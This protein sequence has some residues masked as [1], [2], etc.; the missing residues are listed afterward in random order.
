[1]GLGD[2]QD[3]RAEQISQLPA[4][5]NVSLDSMSPKNVRG[6]RRIKLIVQTPLN[7]G[8]AC[9]S[10]EHHSPFGF[11]SKGAGPLRGPLLFL[12]G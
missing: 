8:A 3:G 11:W 2:R 1:M 4:T 7:Y 12:G 6:P 5:R 9:L 10:Y